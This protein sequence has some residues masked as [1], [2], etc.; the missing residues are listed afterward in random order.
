MTYRTVDLETRVKRLERELVRL[1]GESGGRGLF[2]D[3]PLL[4]FLLFLA[5]V[6]SIS[7]FALHLYA[8]CNAVSETIEEQGG[9]E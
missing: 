5:L 6:S 9:S 3:R 4:A 1:E 7:H 2:R 8:A